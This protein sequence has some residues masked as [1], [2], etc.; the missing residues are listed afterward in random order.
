[1]LWE[2]GSL[3]KVPLRKQVGRAMKLPRPKALQRPES[4]EEDPDPKRSAN[5]VVGTPRGMNERPGLGLPYGGGNL[6]RVI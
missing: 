3:V 1:V 2:Y 4:S 6:A 5:K